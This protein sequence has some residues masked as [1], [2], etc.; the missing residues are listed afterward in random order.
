[1]KTRIISFV[2]ALILMVQ[3]GWAQDATLIDGIYYVFNSEDKTAEVVK[4]TSV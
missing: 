4:P 2:A 1:M 3:G